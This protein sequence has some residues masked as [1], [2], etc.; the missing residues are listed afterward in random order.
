MTHR[1]LCALIALLGACL[2]VPALAQ[3]ELGPEIIRAQTLPPDAA[4]KLDQLVT[5]LTNLDNDD[6]A[7]IQRARNSLLAPL[8]DRQ[9]SVAF[10]TELSGRTVPR[11]RELSK[12]QR[13]FVAINA[14]R[15]AGETATADS[16]AVLTDALAEKRLS[17]RYAAVAG[18]GRT[19]DAIADANPAINPDRTLALIDRIAGIIESEP[20]ADVLDAA[21]RALMSAR[22][23]ERP[24]FE[25]VRDRAFAT[26]TRGVSAR[27]QKM[28]G[29]APE[30][31]SLAAFVRAGKAVRDAIIQNNPRF[32]LADADVKA[33]T[34]LA[35]RLV[36]FVVRRIRQGDLAVI[37]PGDDPAV[38]QAKRDRREPAAL[39][40]A[41]SETIVALASAAT[42]NRYS[43]QGLADE[44]RKTS[45]EGDNAFL[46]KSLSLL[47][48]VKGLGI[49]ADLLAGK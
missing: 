29:G 48:A 45:I 13:D 41:V 25:P 6:P 35:G 19:F 28:G 33:G 46:Q 24:N 36:G 4:G 12:N 43:E 16:A 3:F 1:N 7:L 9:A 44:L 42:P 8:R 31:R 47:N 26:L 5:A 11:L 15:I 20:D 27:L 17:V 18:I 37:A 2:P 14:L 23:I 32:K 40:L 21:V 30:L 39:A 34:E 49:D 22:R 38:V 10:R